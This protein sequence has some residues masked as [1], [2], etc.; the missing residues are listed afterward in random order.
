MKGNL[1]LSSLRSRTKLLLL[2]VIPLIVITALVMAVN[3]Q[4]GLSTLQ[5]ELENYRT[6]LIDA[7]KKE[8][9]AYLMMGVTAVKPL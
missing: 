2:T 6:D 9:Q 1:M 8:L 3:Y 4:S 5:K 7:K